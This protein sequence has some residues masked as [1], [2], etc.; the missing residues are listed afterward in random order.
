MDIENRKEQVKQEIEREKKANEVLVE[1]EE[2]GERISDSAINCPNC[3]YKRK[4]TETAQLLSSCFLGT[5]LL[6]LSAFCLLVSLA[7]WIPL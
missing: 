4:P 5:L 2:C 1:C 6:I 3:G 7:L